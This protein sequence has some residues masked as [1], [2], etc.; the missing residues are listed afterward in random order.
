VQDLMVVAVLF[1]CSLVAAL[2]LFKILQSTAVI[3]KKE[4]QVG[5]A[6]AGFL[7]IYAALYGSYYQLQSVQL[8]GCEAQIPANIT[9]Q[10][11]LDP[12]IKDALVVPGG[13]GEPTD[14][15]GRFTLTTKGVPKTVYV[16]T[17]ETHMSHNILPE[18]NLKQPIKIP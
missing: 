3:Q 10:G 8:A 15:N 13:E 1:A 12:P 4:Y 14:D 2:V 17:G 6:A 11:A 7:L 18:D 5:G 16:I 9:I